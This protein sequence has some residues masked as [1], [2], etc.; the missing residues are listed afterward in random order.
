MIQKRMEKCTDKLD[1]VGKVG[2][3]FVMFAN[4]AMQIRKKLNKGDR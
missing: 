2:C 4:F 1:Q 3:K